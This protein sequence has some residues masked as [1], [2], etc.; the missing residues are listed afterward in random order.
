MDSEIGFD[1][2]ACGKCCNT[3]PAMSVPELFLHRD[4]FIGTL[5]VGRVRRLPQGSRIAEG[6][7]SRVLDEEDAQALMALQDAI[8]HRPD[9][10]NRSGHVLSLVTQ[11]YGYP[12]LERCPALGDDGNCAIHR[13]DKPLMCRVVP[14]DPYLPD[15]LQDSVLLNRRTAGAWMG[16]SC[17]KPG[18]ESPYRPLVQHRRVADAAFGEDL[19][20]RRVELAQEKKR[21][22]WAVAGMLEKELN[23]GPPQRLGDDAYL[24]LPLVP[25]LAVLAAE[26]DAMRGQCVQYIDSQAALIG[27]AVSSAL[28]RKRPEDRAGTAQLRSFA[29]AYARQRTLLAN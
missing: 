3:P 2:N 11:A 14:L 12:S 18:A 9:A 7:G 17:I 19:R 16:A 13:Q 28:A 26:G 4:R 22:G 21:W 24:V 23:Q 25:I 10:S 15:R 1:C 5:A 29:L 8:F 27:K 20:R 6:E